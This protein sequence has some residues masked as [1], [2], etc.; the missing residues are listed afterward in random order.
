[1]KPLTAPTRQ[2]IRCVPVRPNLGIAASYQ[3]KIDNLVA[4]MSRQSSRAILAEYRSKPPVLAQDESS[5]AALRDV[6][7]R[8]SR[9]WEAKFDDFAKS[10]GRKFAHETAS[11]ADRSFA[12]SLRGAGFT[13]RFQPTRAVNE[14][15]QATI[16]EQVSLIRS[17]PK[18]YFTQIQGSVMRS[19]QTGR[20][21]ASLSA[22]LQARYG[23]TKRRAALIARD[24]NN[25]ATASITRARQMEA[26]ITEATWLHSA[27]G[28]TPRPEH[29]AASGKR[30]DVAKGMFLE[31]EWVWPGTAINCR[32]VSVPVIPGID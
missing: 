30:Y 23:V 26:G 19:V 32:C 24:Q 7:A 31:N 12:A 21:L 9:D 29:V 28:R 3:R 14:V 17:I 5:P 20:D 22:D 13:V 10:A 6:I 1:M 11:A 8:L 16:A 15:I 2:P 4:A 18:Q 25:K 27:G